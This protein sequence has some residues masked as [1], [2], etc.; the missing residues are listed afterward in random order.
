MAELHLI[1]E[2]TNAIDFEE[3]NL[4]CK[5]SIQIGNTWKI[6]EGQAEGRTHTDRNRLE[7]KISV[8]TSPLDVH[9]SGRSIQGWPKLHVEIFSVNGLDNKC[10]PVGFGFYNIPIK[11]LSRSSKSV[12]IA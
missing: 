12:F 8:F 7:D 9:L 3:P 1:G 10:H 4:F 6:I 2:I 5:W 11:P